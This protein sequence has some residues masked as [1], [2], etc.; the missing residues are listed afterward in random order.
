[1]NKVSEAAKLLG[2]IK[3]E[4]K[5]RASVANGSMPCAPGKKRGRPKERKSS[6]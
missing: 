1:M 5:A 4:K 6:K 2:K 3:S